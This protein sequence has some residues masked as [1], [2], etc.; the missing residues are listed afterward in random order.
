M[1]MNNSRW[2]GGKKTEEKGESD[3][4][5]GGTTKGKTKKD[6]FRNLKFIKF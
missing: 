4:E 2:K 5:K 1:K 3:E 6:E